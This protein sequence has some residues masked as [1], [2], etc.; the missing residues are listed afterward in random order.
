MSEVSPVITRETT[1][2]KC[3]I[4]FN[5]S[6]SAGAILFGTLFAYL[7]LWHSAVFFHS[8]V[9]Q[10]LGLSFLAGYIFLGKRYWFSIPFRGIILATALYVT[11]LLVKWV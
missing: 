3:W 11:A 6:H 4:G 1:M 8:I 5:A 7:S 9:L 10:L 2:W